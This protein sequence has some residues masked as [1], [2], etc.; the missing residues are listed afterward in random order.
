MF[1]RLNDLYKE[2]SLQYLKKEIIDYSEE[3]LQNIIKNVDIDSN[4]LLTMF[5]NVRLKK[6]NEFAFIDV[7][8]ENTFILNS[9]IVIAIMNY[10]KSISFV[11]IININ[12]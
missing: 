6:S 1:S 5:Y 10:Y 3:D 2:G 12:F 4:K 7:Y 8:D 9:K 11:I